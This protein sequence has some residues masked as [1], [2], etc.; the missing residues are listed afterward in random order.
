MG[1]QRL[2]PKIIKANLTGLRSYHIDI[3]YAD[4]NIEQFHHPMLQRIVNGIRRLRGETSKRERRPITRDILLQL[5]K[6]FDRTTLTSVTH[7]AS[8]C[9]A[10]AGFLRIGEFTWTS[11][12]AA[13]FCRWNLTRG[14][15]SIK[16]NK[17]EL[18]LPSSKTDP[19]RKGVT[20]TIAA[21]N[22][23]ACAVASMRNLT[24][25][26][27]AESTTPLFDPGFPYT[28]G[29]VTAVLRRC[30]AMLRIEGQYSG[31][32][33]RRG[34]ATSARRAGLSDEEI[35]SL[36][37]WKSNS[38]RLYIEASPSYILS[39]SRRLQQ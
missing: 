26:F 29:H 5:I 24:Q 8:F 33:F 3:G 12:D 6:Q 37:R 2:Q 19:F 23:V 13:D 18:I 1:D 30:L 35:Q 31:H 10:F 20:I 39:A 22:D 38:Y 34:A 17:L 16:A 32:S 9:L 28:R 11:F 4:S 25:R 36:G 27:P 21:S 15:I 7:H 14:S